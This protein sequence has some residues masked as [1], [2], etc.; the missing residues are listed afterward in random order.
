MGLSFGKSGEMMMDGPSPFC[1][2]GGTGL[3]PVDRTGWQPV[4]L[5]LSFLFFQQD[6]ACML[7]ILQSN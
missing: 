6:F 7:V 2:T 5:N 4:L 3:W 1:N